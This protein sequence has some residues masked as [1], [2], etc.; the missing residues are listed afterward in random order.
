MSSRAA[1]A[2]IVELLPQIAAA[3]QNVYDDWEQD[4]YGADAEGCVGG[5]CHLIADEICGVLGAAG[6][7]CSPISATVGEQHVWV[8]AK[9]GDVDENGDVE[10]HDAGVW[11]IDIPPHVYESGAAY[12][13]TKLPGVQFRDDDIVVYQ[14]SPDPSDFERY[15]DE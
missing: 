10:R 5:I 12:T 1:P 11:S 3:A 8:V 7:E 6:I 4:E 14:E 9:V 2:E 15:M 13:W